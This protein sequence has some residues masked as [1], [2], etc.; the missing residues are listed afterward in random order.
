[1]PPNPI[2]EAP[3]KRRF[4]FFAARH[5][6]EF[7][8]THRALPGAHLVK[9]FKVDGYD[10]FKTSGY[11]TFTLLPAINVQFGQSTNTS[12]TPF[13]TIKL[14]GQLMVNEFRFNDLIASQGNANNKFGYQLGLKYINVATIN[15]LDLEIEY[16]RVRPYSYTHYTMPNETHPVN[17]YSHFNQPLAHPLGVN[18]TELL[19]TINAQ[20]LPR[21]T[22]ELNLISTKI[23]MDFY[24]IDSIYQGNNTT[25]NG[26]QVMVAPLATAPRAATEP[27]PATIPM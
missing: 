21:L 4:F 17:S 6:K 1:M 12:Y 11:I 20:P 19:L 9:D 25:G 7:F 15:N 27:L 24:P 8:E 2:A 5:E 18:F 22:L 13:K 3:S 16:N 14:Y 23:G 10:Y 26:T